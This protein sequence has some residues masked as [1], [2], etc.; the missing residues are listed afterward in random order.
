MLEIWIHRRI[1]NPN[2]LPEFRGWSIISFVDKPLQ[3]HSGTKEPDLRRFNSCNT[4]ITRDFSVFPCRH[5]MNA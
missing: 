3:I 2:Q 5:C 1:Q 4:T